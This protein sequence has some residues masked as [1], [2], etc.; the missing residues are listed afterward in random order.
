MLS[1]LWTIR[2][3]WAASS[4]VLGTESMTGSALRNPPD[5][6]RR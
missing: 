6:A 1:V 5:C 2:L 4:A 3:I